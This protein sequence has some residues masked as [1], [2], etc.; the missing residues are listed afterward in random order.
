MGAVVHTVNIR[1]AP[2]DLCYI[3]NHAG[4]RVLLVDEDLLPIIEGV[5]PSLQTVEHYVVMTDVVMTDKEEASS[6]LPSVWTYEELMNQASDTFEYPRLEEDR[7]AELCYTSATTGRPKGVT[8]THR[9]IYLH[10]MM[11]CLTDTF[12]LSERDVILPVVP[13]FHANTWGAPYA[14]AFLGANLL[15]P[16]VRPDPRAI[17]ELVQREGVTVAMGYPLYGSGYLTISAAL[18]RSTT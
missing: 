3:I 6:S 13:M 8:Y 16:G 14:C 7:A 9:G 18:K 15:L 12:A 5:A 4:D 11:E 1:L 10:T 2:E 17:C